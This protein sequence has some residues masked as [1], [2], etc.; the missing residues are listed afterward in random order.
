MTDSIDCVVIGAGVVGLACAARLAS[1]GRD[2]VVLERHEL[3][4]SETSSRN[5]EVI[6]AGI[7][8]P[9]D[10][11][12]AR[13]CVA[14]KRKLYAYCEA[15]GVP[16]RNC[17]KLIVAAD[18]SQT[19]VLLDYQT[20][21]RDNDAGELQWLDAKQVR[22]L[23]PAVQA[24]A[25]L[26]SPTT[27]IIDS[28]AYMLSLRGDLEARGGMIALG[29]RVQ[30][31]EAADG[32]ILVV[33]EAMRIQTHTLI[34]CA[35]LQAPDLARQLVAAAP[36]AFFARGH[37]FGYSGRPP[38]SRLV[39][40][41]AEPGGLGVH[42]TLDLSGQIKF[43]PDVEWCDGVDYRFD[44]SR[45]PAFEKAIRRYFPALDSTRLQPGYVGVRPKISAPQEAAADFRIEGPETHGVAGLVN[46]LGIESPGLT[47]SLAIADRVHELIRQADA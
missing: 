20:Q 30:A 44:E 3:I 28:H 14:G 45:K 12:K 39:Y 46:L 9:K 7:Y 19:D 8:Y 40:P 10:S 41:I 25:G 23:E 16:F 17:G 11:W 29:T 22:Q 33:T 13:L 36:R 26:L 42:V 34:N 24:V 47:A 43:G 15:H 31:L 35:G 4:G 6:H 18:S 1:A 32:G 2:V 27:G 21:A 37:Y 38:F 5:S